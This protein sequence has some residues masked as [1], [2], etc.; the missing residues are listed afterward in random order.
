MHNPLFDNFYFIFD[1][2]LFYFYFYFYFL[3]IFENNKL[4]KKD[5]NLINE[6]VKVTFIILNKAF[7]NQIKLNL[8]EKKN[9]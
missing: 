1:F 9:I 7:I 3:G 8:L 2:C 5:E 4:K 6:F